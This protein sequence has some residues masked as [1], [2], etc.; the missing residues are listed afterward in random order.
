V[1]VFEY[2]TTITITKILINNWI[3]PKTIPTIWTLYRNF[4]IERQ[5]DTHAKNQKPQYNKHKN[6][7][8]INKNPY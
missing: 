6:I 4:P 1:F 8:I 7:P 2:S 5:F 3:I